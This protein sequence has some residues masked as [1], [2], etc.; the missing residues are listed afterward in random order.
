[1]AVA[2]GL[3]VVLLA[4]HLGTVT[5]HPDIHTALPLDRQIARDNR[6]R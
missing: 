1:M 6:C 2:R 4:E 3:C 5:A